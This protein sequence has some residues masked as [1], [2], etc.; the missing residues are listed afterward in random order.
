MDAHGISKN[1]DVLDQELRQYSISGVTN[2]SE[3]GED[4]TDLESF[5]H[6]S[7]VNESD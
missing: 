2:L 5:H 3:W 4:K 1:R 6:G 7:G